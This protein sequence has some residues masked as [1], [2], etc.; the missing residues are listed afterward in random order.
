M[1]TKGPQN[2]GANLS[3]SSL[4]KTLNTLEALVLSKGKLSLLNLYNLYKLNL[5]CSGKFIYNL[6]INYKFNKFEKGPGRKYRKMY[7]LS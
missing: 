5:K 7:K 4:N 6:Y 1:N 3:V 2:L